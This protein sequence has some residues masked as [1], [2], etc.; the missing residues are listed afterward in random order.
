M[1]RLPGF[2]RSSNYPP[3]NLGHFERFRLLYVGARFL[4]AHFIGERKIWAAGPLQH[5][6]FSPLA[7]ERYQRA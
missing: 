5:F 6:P 1:L 2:T 3:K 7:Q 4:R